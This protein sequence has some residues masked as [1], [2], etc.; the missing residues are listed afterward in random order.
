MQLRTKIAASAAAASA[1]VLALTLH[2]TKD[3]GQIRGL[4]NA[5]VS[6]PVVEMKPITGDQKTVEAGRNA[7]LDAFFA[8]LERDGS[9]APMYQAIREEFPERYAEIKSTV[10]QEM[11]SSQPPADPEA[12]VVQLTRESL[13]GFKELVRQSSDESLRKVAAAQYSLLTTLALK[14]PA[15][16][17]RYAS[18]GGGMTMPDSPNVMR[19]VIG[20]ATVQIHA[21]G[22][23]ARAPKKRD[24]PAPAVFT[25]LVQMMKA[26]GISDEQVMALGSGK[27]ATLQVEDQ[28]RVAISTY[29]AALGMPPADAGVL[30]AAIIRN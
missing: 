30:L 27:L 5:S 8:S 17:G 29:H 18:E 3:D 20:L 12:R 16:C 28:C 10:R 6:Q 1:V 4:P 14:D 19:A 13:D 2:Y 25:R 23:A 7:R 9:T 26:D 15:A 21:A 22:D 11:E 24:A